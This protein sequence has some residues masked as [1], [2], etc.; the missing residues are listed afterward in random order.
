MAVGFFLNA[1]LVYAVSDLTMALHLDG[2][3]LF[4]IFLVVEFKKVKFNNNLWT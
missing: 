3:K 4:M 1:D 2:N